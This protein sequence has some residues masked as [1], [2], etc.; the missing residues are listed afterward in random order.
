MSHEAH[1]AYDSLAKQGPTI[2]LTFQ[3]EA[4]AERVE[5][6]KAALHEAGVTVEDRVG[7]LEA[8]VV[9]VPTDPVAMQRNHQAMMDLIRVWLG[10]EAAPVTGYHIMAGPESA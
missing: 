6:V 5:Q 3:E 7:L 4:N 10:E 8:N 9:F 1:K 2:R